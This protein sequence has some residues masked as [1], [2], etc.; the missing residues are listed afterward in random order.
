MR[1]VLTFIFLAI[2]LVASANA[3]AFQKDW[4]TTEPYNRNVFK[5]TQ[6]YSYDAVMAMANAIRAEGHPIPTGHPRIFIK[7]NNKEELRKKEVKL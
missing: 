2:L 6:K 7:T 4:T 1:K 5:P 3:Q